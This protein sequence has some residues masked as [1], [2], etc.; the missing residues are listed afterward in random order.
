MRAFLFDRLTGIG[1]NNQMPRLE[2]LSKLSPE[3]LCILIVAIESF[4][5]KEIHPATLTSIKKDILTNAVIKFSETCKPE[6]QDYLHNI[7]I[8]LGLRTGE[9][10]NRPIQLLLKECN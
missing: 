8:F 6:Y 10:K 7:L 2:F 4:L 5:N 3:E 1:Y 9:L